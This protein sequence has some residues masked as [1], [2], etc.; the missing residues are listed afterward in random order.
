MKKQK[1][2]KTSLGSSSRVG[3]YHDGVT[4]L[5]SISFSCGAQLFTIQWRE[6]DGGWSPQH[7]AA[8]GLIAAAFQVETG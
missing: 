1:I 6:P 4:N 5:R 3:F 8:P 7:S 2:K